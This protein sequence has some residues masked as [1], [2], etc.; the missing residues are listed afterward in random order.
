[1]A[2]FTRKPSKCTRMYLVSINITAHLSANGMFLFI[3]SIHHWFRLSTPISVAISGILN[4][5]TASGLLLHSIP[6]QLQSLNELY[7]GRR[8]R[9]ACQKSPHELQRAQ[10][11]HTASCSFTPSRRI[12]QCSANMGLTWWKLSVGADCVQLSGCTPYSGRME[13]VA[14]RR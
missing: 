9:S 13:H 12:G 2:W 10:R 8:G 1:M 5:N 11:G 4:T 6:S 7:W 14:P 3:C